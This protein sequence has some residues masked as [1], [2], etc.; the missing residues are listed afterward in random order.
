MEHVFGGAGGVVEFGA[1][2]QAESFVVDDVDGLDGGVVPAGLEEV[3]GFECADEVDGGGLAEEVVDAEEVV[4]VGDGGEGVFEFC[5]GGGVDAEGFF[6]RQDGAFGQ[7]EV[8]EVVDGVFG[9]VGGEA[10]VDDQAGVGLV[11][12]GVVD[13][14]GQL[15]AVGDVGGDPG[16]G[17]G[18]VVDDLVGDTVDVGV[19][20]GVA[21][22][23]GVVVVV[24]AAAADDADARLWREGEVVRDAG[25]EQASGQVAIAAEDEEGVGCGGV[26]LRHGLP[27]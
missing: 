13:G 15:V 17:V 19:V 12:D 11:V 16:G 14:C 2:F 25:D 21:D 10:V 4:F 22:E 7:G 24:A 26:V 9:D 20:E 1:A 18:E 8:A 6:H 23:A 27:R 5:G 3:V